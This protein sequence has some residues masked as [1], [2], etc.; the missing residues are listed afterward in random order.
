[1]LPADAAPHPEISRHRG[2]DI[3]GIR[4][5]CC[6]LSR[7]PYRSIGYGTG[8]YAKIERSKQ[9]SNRRIDQWPNMSRQPPSGCVNK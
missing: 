2:R 3:G 9:Q 6:R 5:H 4:S 8:K 1:M 7:F